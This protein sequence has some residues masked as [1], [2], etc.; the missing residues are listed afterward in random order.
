M[1]A[2]GMATRLGEL[3]KTV[4]KSMQLVN[5][6]PFIFFKLE[7][8]RMMGIRN[9]IMCV[10]H[11]KKK[12]ILGVGSE[13][14]DIQIQYSAERYPLGTGGAVN[15]SLSL[16][17]EK[18]VLVTNGDTLLS[19]IDKKFRNDF[20]ESKNTTLLVNRNYNNTV[21]GVVNIGSDGRIDKIEKAVPHN[22]F[23]HLGYTILETEK[24]LNFHS[25]SKFDFEMDFINAT[26][27][28]EAYFTF[29]TEADILDIGLPV[30]LRRSS[31]IL[32]KWGMQ[33]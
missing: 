15:R 31:E 24:L 30:H 16:I 25:T 10:G 32:N 5:G 29:L 17:N 9:V 4:P 1:L 11:L 7:E 26:A 23:R 8:I 28:Q 22:S 13:Y 27:K 33:V 2:G 14:K 19:F 6:R 20:L 21:S 18:R 3:A 12:I